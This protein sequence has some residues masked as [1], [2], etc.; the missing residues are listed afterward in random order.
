[1]GNL[2]YIAD[3]YSGVQIID[4]SNPA[5]PAFK[6]SYQT[7]SYANDVEIVGNLAY[8]A[9]DYSGVQ[10]IDISNSASPAL[11]GSYQTSARDV[12]IVGNLAYIANY[13]SSGVQIIDISNTASPSFKAFYG[14]PGHAQAV[15]VV[16]NK[17]YVANSDKGVSIFDILWTA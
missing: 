10:I 5:S 8:I 6:G 14:T 15:K 16:N 12:E 2:A 11:K 13:Y 17:A 3:S 9:G 1:M 4:I 7:P